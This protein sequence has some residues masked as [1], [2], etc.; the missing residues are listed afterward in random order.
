M[1]VVRVS[2]QVTWVFGWAG[3]LYMYTCILLRSPVTL[4]ARRVR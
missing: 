3:E 1:S 2:S 4:P